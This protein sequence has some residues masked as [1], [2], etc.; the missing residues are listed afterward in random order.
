MPSVRAADSHWPSTAAET[1]RC[2]GTRG[3]PIVLSWRPRRPR[4][5]WAAWC[6]VVEMGGKARREI[7]RFDRKAGRREGLL[8]SAQFFPSS[9]LPVLIIWRSVVLNVA[10]WA[11]QNANPPS[12]GGLRGLAALLF[13]D[14][15]PSQ[16]PPRNWTTKKRAT[17]IL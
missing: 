9:R 5:G 4:R 12:L 1:A 2:V 14:P 6:T 10:L 7:L 8:L 3:D 16:T 17:A 13:A 11:L 15:S